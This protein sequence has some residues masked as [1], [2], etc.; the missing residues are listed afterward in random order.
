MKF[1]LWYVFAVAAVLIVAGVIYS[2]E[3]YGIPTF[4][5]GPDACS[6]KCMKENSN[7]ACLGIVFN[8]Q[9][10]G[11]SCPPDFAKEKKP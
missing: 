10:T 11:C 4:G 3:K 2:G 7:P 6:L 9:C 8:G 5:G 1:K